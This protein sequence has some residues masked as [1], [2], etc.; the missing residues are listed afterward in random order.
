MPYVQTRG[1]WNRIEFVGQDLLSS[2]G[3]SLDGIPVKGKGKSRILEQEQ[4][5]QE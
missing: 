5:D 1:M 3:N 2:S 4:D